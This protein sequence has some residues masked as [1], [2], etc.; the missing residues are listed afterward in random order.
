MSGARELV[1]MH[2]VFR[3][4]TLNR[5]GAGLCVVGLVLFLG[6]IT[7]VLASWGSA[8]ST[9]IRICGL[10]GPQSLLAGLAGLVLSAIIFGLAIVNERLARIEARL[11]SMG[12]NSGA[13]N[14]AT[15]YQA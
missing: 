10:S 8:G 5:I 15:E 11:E 14:Q 12:K 4:L 7:S 6:G 1:G 3:H 9:S 2:Q 13:E